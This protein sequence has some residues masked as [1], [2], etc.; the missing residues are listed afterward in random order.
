MLPE[1]TTVAL[2]AYQRDPLY[3]FTE[4]EARDL[5]DLVLG[6]REAFRAIQEVPSKR[7][8]MLH[9]EARAMYELALRAV[10]GSWGE[11]YEEAMIRGK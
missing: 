7:T 6:Y 10:E 11:P 9:A 8:L 1:Q 2:A 4:Q 5:A 3:R